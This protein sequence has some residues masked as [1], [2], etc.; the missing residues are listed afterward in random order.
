MLHRIILQLV[1]MIAVWH[2]EWTV[3][4]KRY[5]FVMLLIQGLNFQGFDFICVHVSRDDHAHQDL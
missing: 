1:G 2:L 4:S 3:V 5:K